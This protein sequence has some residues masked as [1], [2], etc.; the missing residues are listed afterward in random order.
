[1][2]QGQRKP[3]VV[4][5]TIQADGDPRGLIGNGI[6]QDMRDRSGKAV[7]RRQPD[8][9]GHEDVLGVAR[10]GLACPVAFSSMRSR[11]TSASAQGVVTISSIRMTV[12]PPRLEQLK[13][14]IRASPRRHISTGQD[15]AQSLALESG[16]AGEV[17][18]A[19]LD[20]GEQVA[21][22]HRG[23]RPRFFL[24]ARFGGDRGQGAAHHLQFGAAHRLAA[25]DR[26]RH[27]GDK[28]LQVGC[29]G[30]S[31]L[32]GTVG[33]VG[34]VGA[35]AGELD[36][37]P[38]RGAGAAAV[39]D[40]ALERRHPEHRAHHLLGAERSADE[41]FHLGEVAGVFGVDDAADDRAVIADA[42]AGDALAA[43]V[44]FV[45]E[46]QHPG[47]GLRPPGGKRLVAV[48]E[49]DRG[50][51]DVGGDA[52]V[53]VDDQ[54]ATNAVRHLLAHDRRFWPGVADEAI[55][56]PAAGLAVAAGELAD[57][58]RAVEDVEHLLR[59]P[60]RDAR[61]H[62]Q[63]RHVEA[64]VTRQDA[65]RAPQR[66]A[67]G[68]AAHGD[69]AG[70]VD[71]RGPRR[72]FGR[73]G[74]GKAPGR[75]LRPRDQAGADPARQTVLDRVGVRRGGK[76]QFVDGGGRRGV[77]E[78]A[79]QRFLHLRPDIEI[80]GIAGHQAAFRVSTAPIVGDIDLLAVIGTQQ[81]RVAQVGGLRRRGDQDAVVEPLPRLQ[82]G[83]Q[84]LL[85][86]HQHGNAR[87]V[88]D[89]A[90][91]LDRLF[92]H[93]V[94]HLVD[95]QRLRFL[96]QLID[97]LVEQPRRG[98]R[99]AGDADLDRDRL[100][101]RTLRPDRF[102]DDV[103]GVEPGGDGRRGDRLAVARWAIEQAHPRRAFLGILAVEH[104][105]QAEAHVGELRGFAD[106]AQGGHGV[107]HW[108]ISLRG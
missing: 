63:R 72:A 25:G 94:I 106:P 54:A 51:G 102:R 88:V 24:G 45:G 93:E 26:S 38:V 14:P 30:H 41:R 1:M 13:S 86:D 96:Q 87:I 57:V 71:A 31:I 36:L 48:G 22:H 10:G 20:A 52:G 55:G 75:T 95:D 50:G 65:H 81:P 61:G 49:A 74:H 11:D 82:L 43:A 89:V 91:D 37:R 46:Q 33:V 76:V 104:R 101:Q 17:G 28:G 5:F 40:A 105:R 34:A 78:R 97:D 100:Q 66:L 60:A 42:V 98:A 39:G 77:A 92:C 108:L 62:L 73:V 3:P 6:A 4:A 85:A 12:R 103:R 59:R 79:P 2:P 16:E 53:A 23:E 69:A 21:Q 68:A 9:V 80:D 47:G 35:G 8:D 99:G 19:I 70:K 44:A 64:A 27:V 15:R 90:D 83:G 67:R 107:G 29:N 7:H 56:R 58:A 84:R 18:G 32:L